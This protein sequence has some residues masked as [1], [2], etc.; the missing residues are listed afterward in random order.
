MLDLFF[1]LLFQI[2]QKIGENLRIKS[3]KSSIY[4][5]SNRHTNFSW[6]IGK[7]ILKVLNKWELFK[8]ILF[9][10]I[11][12]GWNSK[13]LS[14][15]WFYTAIHIKAVSVVKVSAIDKM[16]DPY[17]VKTIDV[18]YIHDMVYYLQENVS[19]GSNRSA[20]PTN[21]KDFGF[22]KVFHDILTPHGTNRHLFK[23]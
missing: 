19:L 18:Q 20:L 4:N 23:I 13:K 6:Q 11:N 21:R 14:T 15:I 17:T 7:S 2:G 5:I 16:F 8:F 22:F 10:T 9:F 12:K 1:T 3:R